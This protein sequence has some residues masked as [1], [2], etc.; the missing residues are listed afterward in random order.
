[1][2]WNHFHH[3]PVENDDGEIVGMISSND[4]QRLKSNEA[5]HANKLVSDCMTEDIITVTPET[6]LE[7]AEKIM[8]A[9]GFGSLPV[10]R[11]SRVIGIVTANDIRAL[12]KKQ[13]CEHVDPDTAESVE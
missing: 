11:D 7:T 13:Q 9:N 12:R 8:L 10:V 2:E 1:M 4:I 5:Q 6:A 3:L